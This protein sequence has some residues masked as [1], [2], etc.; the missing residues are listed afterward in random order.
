MG[1]NIESMAEYLTDLTTIMSRRK[2]GA[3]AL[4]ACGWGMI[5]MDTDGETDKGDGEASGSE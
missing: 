4:A 5:E 2:G 3:D 1:D